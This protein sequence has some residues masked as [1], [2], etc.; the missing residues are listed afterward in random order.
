MGSKWHSCHKILKRTT[1]TQT[2]SRMVAAATFREV[3]PPLVP[4]LVAHQRNF[5]K[6]QAY[7]VAIAR[8]AHAYHRGDG[9]V[10]KPRQVWQLAQR[11]RKA[12]RACDRIDGENVW[13]MCYRITGST[14][15]DDWQPLMALMTAIDERAVPVEHPVLVVVIL[16][17]TARDGRAAIRRDRG[18]IGQAGPPPRVREG[19]PEARRATRAARYFVCPGGCS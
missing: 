6:R 13:T 2:R 10:L 7:C 8:L 11:F 14:N 9:R 5:R 1:A 19:V 16:T 12:C 15:L 4:D 17:P 18:Y 3:S